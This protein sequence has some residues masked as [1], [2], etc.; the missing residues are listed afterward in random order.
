MLADS[1]NL[2]LFRRN[3][4]LKSVDDGLDLDRNAAEYMMAFANLNVKPKDSLSL[5]CKGM[6]MDILLLKVD[7]GYDLTGEEKQDSGGTESEGEKKHKDPFGPVM[8]GM[9]GLSSE[10]SKHPWI[11][12]FSSTKHRGIRHAVWPDTMTTPED[13]YHKAHPFREEFHPLLRV[14]H[15]SGRRRFVEHLKRMYLSATEGEKPKSHYA[16]ESEKKWHDHAVKEK[17]PV[18]LGRQNSRGERKY[19]FGGP[20]GGAVSS[21]Q[22][23]YERDFRRW[24]LENGHGNID[25]SHDL[26]E[27]HFDSRADEWEGEDTTYEEPKEKSFSYEDVFEEIE[28]GEK[29]EGMHHGHGLG[30]AAYMLGMEW[31]SPQERTAVLEHMET[32]GNVDGDSQAIKLPDGTI[33]PAARF[34]YNWDERITPELNWWKRSQSTHAPNAHKKWESNENDFTSGENRFEQLGLNEAAHRHDLPVRDEDDKIT[35]TYN[36]ANTILNELNQFAPPTTDEEG[37]ELEGKGINVLPRFQLH[38]KKNTIPEAHDWKDIKEATLKHQKKKGAELTSDITK[39]SREDLLYL[40]G[41]HPDTEEPLKDHPIYG[42]LENPV[43]PK[44]DINEILDLAKDYSGQMAQAKDIVNTLA[45]KRSRFGPR[46]GDN[47]ELYDLN[48]DGSHTTGAGHHWWEPYAET[49]GVGRNLATYTEF[50]HHM[51][52]DP[53]TG[54]SI[55]GEMSSDGFLDVNKNLISIAGHLAPFVKPHQW[56]EVPEM[57]KGEKGEIKFQKKPLIMPPEYLLSPYD[58]SAMEH[59]SDGQLV[60]EGPS[61]KNNFTDHL[62]TRSGKYVNDSLSMSPQ[63]LKLETGKQY[64]LPHP[65]HETT[66]ST[67]QENP[68]GEGASDVISE[69]Q[70]INAHRLATILGRIRPFDNPQKKMVNNLKTLQSYGMPF[71]TGD[72]LDEFLNFVGL[73]DQRGKASL[74][75]VKPEQMPQTSEDLELQRGLRAVIKHLNTKNPQEIAQYLNNGDFSDMSADNQQFISTLTERIGVIHPDTIEDETPQEAEKRYFKE[76]SKQMGKLQ[77]IIGMGAYSPSLPVEGNIAEELMMLENLLD[78]E[79]EAGEMTPEGITR[80]HERAKDLRTRLLGLQTEAS[81][82]QPKKKSGWWKTKA[83]TD[84]DIMEAD[85]Q[86][87]LE[88]AKILLPEVKEAVPHSFPE[89]NKMQWNHDNSQLCRMAERALLLT[90]HNSHGLKSMSYGIDS[91]I[92]EAPTESI[93]SGAEHSDIANHLATHGSVIDGNMSVNQALKELGLPTTPEHKEHVREVINQSNKMNTPLH[94][95]TM[96]SL[97]TDG[98]LDEIHGNDLTPFHGDDYH[99]LLRE[100]QKSVS[101]KVSNWNSHALHSIPRNMIQHMNQLQQGQVMQNHGLNFIHND[102]Y[103]VKGLKNKN[104]KRATRRSQNNLDSLYVLNPDA[105]TEDGSVAQ[106]ATPEEVVKTSDWAHRPISP[107]TPESQC[108]IGCY[109]DSGRM[110]MGWDDTAQPSF[111]MEIGVDGKRYYGTHVTPGPLHPVSEE[112]LIGLHGKET[113]NNVMQLPGVTPQQPHQLR[114]IGYEEAPA[115]RDPNDISTGEMTTFLTSLLNP[116]VMLKKASE[117]D[118]VPLIRPMHRIFSLDD[119]K[120]F[121]GFSDSWVVS[122]WYEGQRLLLVKDDDVVFLDENGKQNGVPKKIRDAASKLS[123]KDF[124]IDGVLKDDEFFVM[125]IISYDGTDSSDMNTNERL[126]I[127]RGQLESYD[128]ISIPGPYNTRVTDE[129]GLEGAVEE[130]KEEGRVLLRDAQ[131][132]Y[133]KGEKRHPKWLI[134][135]EGKNM[136]FIILDKRGKG[137]FTYQ[138]GAGPITSSEDLG[139]RA[140]E[141]DG[142]YYMDVGTAH[143]VE[144]PFVEGDIVEASISGVTKKTRGGRDIFNVQFS[145]VDKE[146]EGEGPASAESLSLL[147]KSYPPMIIPHDL[148]F[149]GKILKVV[150]EDIDT[151]EYE[152]LKFNNSWFLHT[153]K[154]VM[155]DLSKSNYSLKLSESLRPFWEPVASLMLNGYVE[156]MMYSENEDE[157]DE[158]ERIEEDSAGILNQKEKNILLKPSMVKA[159]EVAL[160]ALDVISKEKMTT[161]GTKGLGIDMATPVESPRGATSLRDESTLPDWDMRPRPGEEPEKPMSVDKKGKERLTHAKLTTNEGESVDFDVE[162]DQPTVRFS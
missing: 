20:L 69:R 40:A 57:D 111:G 107:P 100:G 89:D 115:T 121:K 104:L 110:D 17:S 11:D 19:H 129:G 161:S 119:L 133:M 49:G 27:E 77:N 76:Q 52:M 28:G 132:T 46:P 162:N 9:E 92:K 24:K 70:A 155:G 30:W 51:L 137:P 43:I 61:S 143:R 26:R 29:D 73:S 15:V 48:A 142:K 56:E 160:R 102:L 86:A 4:L 55:L 37:N 16:T 50:I 114:Q 152:T 18:V 106:I 54:K 79:K 62:S 41:Y 7:E 125:D 139:N 146:G 35:G 99:Q 21:N 149:D 159:L 78:K 140:V 134:L 82:L 83:K 44:N 33:V 122:T 97:L 138:L 59:D 124:I 64:N 2:F 154:C 135:R 39:L 118:W 101:G 47:D 22:D 71:S 127:L 148:D 88:M 67:D 58:I 126:K 63:E 65:H 136:N 150:I 141:L 98:N 14:D 120:E 72:T 156:K 32:K 157:E 13:E 87:I 6:A 117:D 45:H 10:P 113:V 80:M 112:G 31:L 38:H 116:D 109:W 36:V 1:S 90:E 84:T 3:Q 96:N 151:V 68:Y 25:D 12:K 103:G 158:E 75:T 23:L 93:G 66:F 108:S 123:D 95:S 145:S 42:E 34:A 105:V 60:R 85:Q 53:K 74:D 94:V 81:N 8:V 144:K 153:P 91:G 130:L 5:I 147:T 131:S 128:G